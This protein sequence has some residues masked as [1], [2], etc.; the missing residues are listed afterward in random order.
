MD[1]DTYRPFDP[2]RPTPVKEESRKQIVETHYFNVDR[3]AFSSAQVG[4]FERFILHENNG[5][6]VGVLAVTAD[7]KIPFVKQ[8]VIPTHR[9]TLRDSGRPCQRAKP[10]VSGRCKPQVARG[11]R[12]RG[13]EAHPVHALHQHAQLL[14]A[15]HRAVSGDGTQG[16]Q[17]FRG[18]GPETPRSAVRLYTQQEAMEMVTNGTIV[19][20]KTII[21]ILRLHEG[22]L[23]HIGM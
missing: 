10:A 22:L 2:W 14:L 18:I 16:G 20:A 4:Q 1:S 15:V 3:V 17:P 23:E 13:F 7:G 8:Y 21:A 12:L 5:D 6:T 11:G 9:W 19:D